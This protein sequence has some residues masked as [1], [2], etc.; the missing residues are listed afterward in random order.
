MTGR[1]ASFFPFSL[2]LQAGFCP[3]R[4]GPMQSPQK[5]PSS[6]PIAIL[7]A[8][9]CLLNL[10]PLF[11]Q[12]IRNGPCLSA[13]R[14]GGLRQIRTD[15]C[16]DYSKQMAKPARS[17]LGESRRMHSA[18]IAPLY[19]KR[20]RA[21]MLGSLDLETASRRYPGRITVF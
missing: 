13:G 3:S 1:D 20:R 2:R 5:E 17:L 6:P 12:T 11:H 8:S 16:E 19:Y 18:L 10:P 15:G 9:N 21:S 14:N 7:V 4:Q